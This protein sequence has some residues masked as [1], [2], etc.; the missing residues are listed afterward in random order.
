MYGTVRYGTIVV[1]SFYWRR[2]T[3]AIWRCPLLVSRFIRR[4]LRRVI[5]SHPFFLRRVIASHPFFLAPKVAH[6]DPIGR[7][8]R[9][10]GGCLAG[11]RPV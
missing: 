8:I 4:T 3:I 1:Q 10:A 9:H 11:I 5:A 2:W 7:R 6:E